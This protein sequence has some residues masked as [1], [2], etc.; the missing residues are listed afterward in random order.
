[1]S[2]LSLETFLDNLVQ[3]LLKDLGFYIPRS[4]FPEQVL[5]KTGIDFPEHFFDEI[6]YLDLKKGMMFFENN[7]FLGK[8]ME[9]P[10]LLDNTIIQLLQKKEELGEAEF[11]YVLEKYFDRVNF[12]CKTVSLLS[13]KLR[14]YFKDTVDFVTISSFELQF[15]IYKNHLVEMKNRFYKEKEVIVKEYYELDEIVLTY[16]PDFLSRL[17]IYYNEQ[18]KKSTIEFKPSII[19]EEKDIQEQEESDKSKVPKKRVKKEPLVTD[20]EAED[21][22]LTT[23]F[24]VK[25]DPK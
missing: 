5:E 12:Y 21:F 24:N 20:Q 19:E 15:D 3:V 16:L 17:G 7:L 13:S 23:V 9:K 4:I 25:L 6:F 2:E 22:L 18:T 14:F 8:L 10:R 1:M 11:D